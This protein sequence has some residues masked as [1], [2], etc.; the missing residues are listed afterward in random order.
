MKRRA[1]TLIEFIIGMALAGFLFLVIYSFF[2]YS[3][4]S[5]EKIYDDGDIE[6]VRYAAEYIANEVN[7][8]VAVLPIDTLVRSG[9]GKNYLGFV[10]VRYSW[11]D[12]SSITTTR[13]LGYRGAR[14]WFS[15]ENMVDLNEYLIYSVYY[16]DNNTLRRSAKTI[17]KA[18]GI[19]T[20]S[21]LTGNNAITDNIASIEG[22][23]FDPNLNLL[24]IRFTPLI[25]GEE[26]DRKKI[27][28]DIFVKGEGIN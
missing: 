9:D 23:S 4:I 5:S 2:G 17:P 3:F 24:R 20:I 21:S 19:N 10:I 7:Q 12:M 25:G 26:C 14:R 8:A 28:L 13:I 1:F 16:L 15:L 11:G 22:T 27:S 18:K 6:S